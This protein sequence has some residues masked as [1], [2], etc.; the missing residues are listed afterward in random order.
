M[1][2]DQ[3]WDVLRRHVL[4]VLTDL[5]DNDV[6]PGRN[7]RELGANSLDRVDILDATLDELRLKIPAEALGATPDLGGLVDLLHAHGERP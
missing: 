1:T 5:R 2:H 4:D 7:L 3:I 6:Q